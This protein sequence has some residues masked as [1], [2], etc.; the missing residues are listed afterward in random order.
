MIYLILYFAIALIYFAVRCYKD[1]NEMGYLDIADVSLTLL[2]SIFW[3][4]GLIV[5]FGFLLEDFNWDKLW[6]Y[7]IIKK[8]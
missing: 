7:K 2:L 6:N 8:K 5:M 3:P 1:Y 4:G